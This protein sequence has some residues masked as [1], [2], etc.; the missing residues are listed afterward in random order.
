MDPIIN[1]TI[2]QLKEKI[3]M[4]VEAYKNAQNERD[5]LLQEKI[6]L[7]EKIDIIT[8]EKREL[9]HR[10]NSLKVSKVIAASNIEATEAKERINKIMREIDNCVALLNK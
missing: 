5:S 10:Y 7:L 4:L 6:E 9:E 8:E 2:I 3:N 1:E